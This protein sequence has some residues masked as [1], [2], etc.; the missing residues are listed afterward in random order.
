MLIDRYCC[1]CIGEAAHAIFVY[2]SGGVRQGMVQMPKGKKQKKKVKYKCHELVNRSGTLLPNGYLRPGYSIGELLACLRA[3]VLEGG[4]RLKKA[5]EITHFMLPHAGDGGRRKHC[6][7]ACK[8]CV[9]TLV[10]MAVMHILPRSRSI[11][12]LTKWAPPRGSG[13][14]HQTRRCGWICKVDG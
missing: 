11:S 8:G 13:R 6:T 10:M 9:I 14:H 4:R 1:C 7:M 5:A 2:I 3:L 12:I